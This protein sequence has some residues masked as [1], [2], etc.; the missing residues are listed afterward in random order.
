MYSGVMGIPD[1]LTLSRMREQ[2]EER[3]QDILGSS[4]GRQSS[5]RHGKE[6]AASTLKRDLAGDRR[7]RSCIRKSRNVEGDLPVVHSCRRT[8]GK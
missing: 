7:E 2:T 6:P 3:E 8:R 1:A 5:T 4:G